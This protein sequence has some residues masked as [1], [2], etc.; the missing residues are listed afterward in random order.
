VVLRGSVSSNTVEAHGCYSHWS[1]KYNLVRRIC[2]NAVSHFRTGI[3]LA[4]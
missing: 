1:I 3:D 4:V 2:S